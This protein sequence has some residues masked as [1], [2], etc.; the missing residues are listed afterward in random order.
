M[1]ILI[2]IGK[3]LLVLLIINLLIIAFFWIKND[4]YLESTN[5]KNLSYLRKNKKVVFEKEESQYNLN[6]F[7][8]EDFYNSYVFL[9]GENHGFAEVQNID[10]ELFNHLNQKIG[11]K[12]YIAE[13]D[14]IRSRRLNQYLNDS[15]KNV[16][17]EKQLLTSLVQICKT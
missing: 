9:L 14:S 5:D 3:I 7:F 6:G 4:N 13:M 2:I 12:Y 8:D 1:R 15:I 11:V 16:G 10:F 17:A